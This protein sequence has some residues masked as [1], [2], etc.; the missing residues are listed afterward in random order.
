MSGGVGGGSYIISE[1][2]SKECQLHEF[3]VSSV[4]DAGTSQPAVISE[5]IPISEGLCPLTVICTM[6]VAMA[7]SSLPYSYPL[8]PDHVHMYPC[9][10][11]NV[12]S[13]SNSLMANTI[14]DNGTQIRI[15]FEVSTYLHLY[16][17]YIFCNYIAMCLDTLFSFEVL[18]VFLFS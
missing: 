2:S 14:L 12:D 5:T 18:P 17:M 10:A 15:S 11:P 16:L 7:S 3:H 13:I 6:L 9:T 4:N 8:T 1:N